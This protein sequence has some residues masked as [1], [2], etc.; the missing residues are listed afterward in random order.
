MENILIKA[1]LRYNLTD[2]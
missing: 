2:R 1:Y